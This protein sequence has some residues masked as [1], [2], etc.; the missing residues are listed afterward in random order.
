MLL[1]EIKCLVLDLL[2][3]G[4]RLCLE[5]SLDVKETHCLGGIFLEGDQ[6]SFVE[7]TFIWPGCQSTTILVSSQ[8]IKPNHSFQGICG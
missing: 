8:E 2:D 1:D 5:G 4:V 7:E 6:L 3:E